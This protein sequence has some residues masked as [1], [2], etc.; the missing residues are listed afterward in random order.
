MIR[1]K[2]DG[3]A[4]LTLG[5]N[6]LDLVLSDSTVL[7]F[8]GIQSGSSGRDSFADISLK[9]PA[10]TIQEDL[11]RISSFS[12]LLVTTPNVV[13][14]IPGR[15][16]TKFQITANGVAHVRKGSMSAVWIDLWTMT[17]LVANTVTAGQTFRPPLNGSRPGAVPIVRPT[18]E[19]DLTRWQR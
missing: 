9:L 10:G 12:M 16:E 15:I 19:A 1:S 8:T 4:L 17:N 13:F 7:A 6:S 5:D 18:R 3:S 2:E 14:V 11:K